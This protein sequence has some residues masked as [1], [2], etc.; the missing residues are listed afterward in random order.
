MRKVMNQNSNFIK[1]FEELKQ[2]CNK[3]AG[4]ENTTFDLSAASENNL[5][6]RRNKRFIGQIKEIRN[7]L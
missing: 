2:I 1:L 3:I 5:I 6:V 4:S 7:L